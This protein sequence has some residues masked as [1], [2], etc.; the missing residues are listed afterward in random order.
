MKILGVVV[1]YFPQIDELTLNVST[2]IENLDKLIVWD[3]TPNQPPVFFESL[4]ALYPD[5]L[6]ILGSGRNEGIGLALNR[7]AEWGLKNNYDFLLT[8]DQDSSFDEGHFAQY[9]VQI[10][11]NDHSNVLWYAA[12]TH[13]PSGDS[14][15]FE[16]DFQELKLCITS[17]SLVPLPVFERIGFFREDFFIEGVDYEMCFRSKSYGLKIL[18]VNRVFLNHSV[19]DRREHKL[20]GKKVHTFN[21]SPIRVYYSLRNHTYLHKL[22]GDKAF[23]RY[24]YYNW[25]FKRGIA[26]LLYESEKR[27]KWAAMLRGIYDGIKGF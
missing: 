15:V 22:Y 3:N 21:Y 2:Y 18:Q 24:F 4:Q 27:K 8:M 12:M 25:F 17:G 26:I 5:K 14:P 7:A 1:A 9:L 19:G 16:G 11:D 6:L 13:L 10:R 23:I 20:F